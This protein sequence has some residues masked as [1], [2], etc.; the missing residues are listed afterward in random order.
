M[1]LFIYH[2]LDLFT[3]KDIQLRNFGKLTSFILNAFIDPQV[4]LLPLPIG[5]LESM[6]VEKFNDLDI[7]I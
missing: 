2:V 3:L 5:L 7:T 4:Y 6:L 1:V